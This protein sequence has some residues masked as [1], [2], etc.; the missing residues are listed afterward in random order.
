MTNR[1]S[2][3]LVLLLLVFPVAHAQK[4]TATPGTYELLEGATMEFNGK[5][6]QGQ[7]APVGYHWE[8]F[9]GQD[10]QL[11][12]ADQAK[13]T[14]IAPLLKEETRSFTL[15]LT[16][17]YAKEKSSS[18]QIRINVHRKSRNSRQRR[19]GPW[20]SGAIGFGFGYLWGGWWP[21]PPIIVIPCPLPGEIILPEDLLP[22]A[23]PYG[24]DPEYDG[25]IAD[26]PEY[27]DLYDE[28]AVISDEFMDSY[29]ADMGEFDS[30]DDAVMESEGIVADEP[31]ID[32]V[33][34]PI[35]E[36]EPMDRGDYDDGDYDRGGYDRGGYDDGGYDDGSYGGGYDDG[37]FDDF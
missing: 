23:T 14:F 11:V 1:K 21:Y 36:R 7:V 12:N 17:A 15:Q 31:M 33:P 30:M 24:D 25:W 13:V 2:L 8:I 20:L 27:E 4:I 34:E 29:E 16:L 5:P 9:S 10:G 19:S 28:D 6:S 32:A 3:F 18:A 22:I 37:G 26:N 35:I